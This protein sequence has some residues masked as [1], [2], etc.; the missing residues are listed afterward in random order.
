M[1][2]RGARRNPRTLGRGGCQSLTIGLQLFWLASA[3]V[4]ALTPNYGAL[5][6]SYMK[7]VQASFHLPGTHSS[8][9]NFAQHYGWMMAGGLVFAGAILGLLVYYRPRFL[10]VAWRADAAP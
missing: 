7:E 3:L 8:P 10:E 4:S 2:K 6:D 9:F 5:M 1:R